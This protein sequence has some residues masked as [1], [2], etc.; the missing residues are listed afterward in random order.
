MIERIINKYYRIT[1]L[2]ILDLRKKVNLGCGTDIRKGWINCD[3]TSDNDSVI[4]LDMTSKQDLK[5]I[6]TFNPSV[7]EMNH[8]IGYLSYGEAMALFESLY[9]SLKKGGLLIIETPCL[10]KISKQ[11]L[12]KKN[13]SIESFLETVRALYA[14]DYGEALLK[15]RHYSPYAFSW[16]EFILIESLKKIGFENVTSKNPI[17]HG[18]RVDRDIRIV[19]VK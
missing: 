7:I 1:R 6:E 8:S 3:I 5:M 11:H 10:S 19:S 4:Q 2:R 13:E 14:F 17:M 12:E 18:R 15:K 9:N 16:S